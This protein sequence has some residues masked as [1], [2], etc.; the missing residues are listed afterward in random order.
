MNRND[1]EAVEKVLA[2]VAF[3][4]LFLQIL[5]RCRQHPDVHFDGF[6][7]TDTRDLALLQRPQHLGLRG[8]THVSYLIEEERSSVGLLELA[9]TVFDRSGE[10]AFHMSEEF[11]LN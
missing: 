11:A 4:N 1:I 8:K 3:G 2:E 5:V 10:R 6:V 7:R 9:R